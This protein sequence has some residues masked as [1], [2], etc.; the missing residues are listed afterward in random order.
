MKLDQFIGN[1]IFRFPKSVLVFF[2]LL[3]VGAGMLLPQ[4]E[5][6]PTPYLL[7][8]EHESRVN[9]EKLREMYTGA[10]D[11]IIVLLEAKETVF[12]PQTLSRVAALTA[13]FEQIHVITQKDRDALFAAADAAPTQIARMAVG[14]SR[15]PITAETWMQIDGLREAIDL[16]NDPGSSAMTALTLILNRWMENLSPIREVTSLSNTDNIVGR[17]GRLDVSPLFT[18]V[19]QTGEALTRVEQNAM[20]NDLFRQVL[21]SEGGK[22]TGIILEL[23]GIDDQTKI[24]YQVYNRVKQIVEE[25]IPGNEIHYI[26]GLPVVTGSLGKVMEQ[27]TQKLFP[28]VILIV[29]ICLLITFRKLKGILVPLTVVILSLEVTLG[30]K[31]LFHIPLNIITTTLPVFILSIGVADGIHMFSEYRDQLLKGYDKKEAVSRTLAHLTM[32]V[33]MTSV[34][35]AVAFYAI[36]LTEIVQLHHFGIFVSLGAMVAMVFS[37]FFIPALLVLLPEKKGISQKRTSRIEAG[38]AHVLVRVTRAFVRHPIWTSVFAAVVF[39]TSLFGASKVVVDNNNA[40]YFLKSSDIY[41]SSQKLNKDSAGSAVINFLITADT[42][43][44]EP[45]KQAE[46][47]LY[48]DGLVGFLNEEPHVGKVL[49]LTELIK[50]INFTLNDE[51]EGFNRIPEPVKEDPASRHLISQLLLLYENGGGDTLTDFTDSGYTQLNIPVILQTNS[52]RDI[53]QLSRA[54]EAYADKHFPDNMTLDISGSANVSVAATDEIVKGQMTSL[55]VSLAVVLAML[56]LTFRKAS[57]AGIAIVPL[58]IAI[59]INFGIMGYFR[60]PLDIGTAIISSI[61]IG[62]GVDYAIHYLSRL[63][64]NLEKGMTFSR[65]LEDTISHSGKAIVSNAATV[66]FGFVALWF[67]VLTPLFVMGWM[68]TLTM[69]VSAFATIVLIPVL[70]L[71]TEKRVLDEDVEK[72]KQLILQPQDIN[73]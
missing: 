24:Q 35:T 43:E 31:V 49:G 8:I 71:F 50:R 1:I 52:S 20:S 29:I 27:D 36:S 47:L 33:I 46:N 16:S 38:Y 67:S 64:K 9:L 53:Y 42:T 51:E 30:V 11:G 3:A 66:G 69:L 55:M 56:F 6:D 68:I 41:I 2:I 32:P 54:A 28:I 48:V 22:S 4:I 17:N 37:L 73:H 26:A 72:V 63:K 14:L 7:P 15:A 12:N 45:F 59:T 62:I 34:T 65:A 18:G 13:A 39:L 19:P 40:A 61:V 23:N 58:I 10:N 21:I 5:R 44:H 57:Y 70:L 25:Q 60:I